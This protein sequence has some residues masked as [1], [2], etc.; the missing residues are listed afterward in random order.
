MRRLR[1]LLVAALV[2]AIL[3][4]PVQAS[5]GICKGPGILSVTVAASDT[6]IYSGSP[7]LPPKDPQGICKGP[8]ILGFN[9]TGICKGPGIL[10]LWSE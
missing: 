3:L 10:A 7:S 5:A 8:G 9:P 1:W 2:V 6:P 4:V